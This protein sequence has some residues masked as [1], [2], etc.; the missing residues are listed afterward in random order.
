MNHT[1]RL[2]KK[3][4]DQQTQI[5]VTLLGLD[6]DKKSPTAPPPPPPPPHPT[7]THKTI[8]NIFCTG[9]T[10]YISLNVHVSTR[11][12]NTPETAG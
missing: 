7:H 9:G 4:M 3:N 10:A 6:N 11:V 8:Y 2:L 12:S 1:A 5:T